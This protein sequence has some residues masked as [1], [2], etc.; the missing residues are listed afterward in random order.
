M[1]PPPLAPGEP[2]RSWPRGVNGRV[3]VCTV[4]WASILVVHRRQAGRRRSLAV[5][6]LNHVPPGF[7]S[8]FISTFGFDS[9]FLS[10]TMGG[11]PCTLPAA[12]VARALSQGPFARDL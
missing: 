12:V 8:A 9:G 10:T 11:E 4:A 5:V 6:D 1:E 7:N 2:I 3:A